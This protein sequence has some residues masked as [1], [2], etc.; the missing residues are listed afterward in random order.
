MRNS[1]D[2][3]Q[4]LLVRDTASSH[5]KKKPTGAAATKSQAYTMVPNVARN[6][7]KQQQQQLKQHQQSQ[8]LAQAP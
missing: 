5:Q 7:P 4:A 6:S 3:K 8:S 1:F 2:F